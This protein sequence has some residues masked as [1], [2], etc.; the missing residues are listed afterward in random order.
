MA[1]IQADVGICKMGGSE[2]HQTRPIVDVWADHSVFPETI[3]NSLGIEPKRQ[4]TVRLPDGNLADWGYGVALLEIGDQ[5]WPCPVVFSPDDEYRLGASALQIFNMDPDYNTS[6]LAPAEPILLGKPANSYAGE[7]APPTSVA[8][9]SG[10][11]IWLRYADGVAGEVDLSH[12]ADQEAF[13]QWSDRRFF[14]SV[15]LRPDGVVYWGD[16]GDIAL[17]S[18]A[19]YLE[20]TSQAG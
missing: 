3:L 17:C 12:L 13:A 1:E 8:P 6:E 2:F 10:Y 7:F 4:Q 19:L 11:R 18:D 5:Q 20:L 16:G 15:N 14:R 9:L